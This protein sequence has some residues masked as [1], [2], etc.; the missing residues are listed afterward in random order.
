MPPGKPEQV[1]QIIPKL[2]QG[3]VEP[4]RGKTVAE[5]VKIIRSPELKPILDA[6]AKAAPVKL[7][8]GHD[9]DADGKENNWT[10]QS[11]HG[12][13]ADKGVPW[14]YFG[15]E[16]HPDYH[17]P[18]DTFGKIE[19]GFFVRSVRT[20]AEFVRRLDQGLDPVVAAK[21]RAAADK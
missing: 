5:A 1:E 8:L 2:R 12:A 18:S 14:V 9:T 19:Q 15:V 7:K 4:A 11:D 20:I 6:V 16:D 13:F 10:S 3:E 17:Q 21:A